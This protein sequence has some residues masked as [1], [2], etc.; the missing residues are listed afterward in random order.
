MPHE[1]H[2]RRRVEFADTD[3]AGILHFSNYFRFMESAEHA[4]LRSLGVS[5]HGEVDGVAIGW[6]R[7]H[8]TCDY[9]RPLRFEDEVDVHL[10]VREKREKSLSYEF[11]LRKC[12]PDGTPGEEVARGRMTV[13]CIGIAPGAPMRGVA[14]PASLAGRIEVAPE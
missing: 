7:V 3:A 10:V 13:V 4:F 11:V 2:Y 8:A 5:A 6:P 1:F 12:E 14:I 9:R